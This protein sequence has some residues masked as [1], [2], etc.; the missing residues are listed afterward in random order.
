MVSEVPGPGQRHR[1]GASSGADFGFWHLS[2]REKRRRLG[3]FRGGGRFMGANFTQRVASE[4]PMAR[5]FPRCRP[6]RRD[7]PDFDGTAGTPSVCRAV[8]AAVLGRHALQTCMRLCGCAGGSYPSHPASPVHQLHG[9]E[10]L[11]VNEPQPRDHQL[12]SVAYWH[13]PAVCA[14]SF[15]HIR[16]IADG[17]RAS[18]CSHVTLST[19]RPLPAYSRRLVSLQAAR[20]LCDAYGMHASRWQQ[21]ACV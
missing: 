11:G 13:V 1:T 3:R 20:S 15:R 14:V 6:Q 5:G 16:H 18:G 9:S 7:T 10:A 19:G 17:K 21:Q 4:R 12:A 8:L 2:A